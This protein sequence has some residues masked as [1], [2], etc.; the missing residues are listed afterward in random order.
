MGQDVSLHITL[1][2]P[3]GIGPEVV[4]SSLAD[5][6]GPKP[7]IHGHREVLARAARLLDLPDPADTGSLVR[8]PDGVPDPFADPGRTQW[9][10]LTEATQAAAE[11]HVDALVTAPINKETI[12]KAGFSFPGHTDYLAQRAGTEAA[13]MFVGPSLRVVLATVHLPLRDVAEVLTAEKLT[14]VLRLALRSLAFDFGLRG[15]RVAVAGLNPHAGEGGL[16]GDEE[17]RVLLPAMDAC[18]QI[19]ASSLLPEAPLGEG[20]TL[21]GPFPADTVFRQ[22]QLGRYDA[23]VAMYHDQALI[24]V[25]LLEFE[26]TVNVT[27]GLPYVRTSPA[28]GT[29]A[30]IAW[31]GKASSV[32]MRAALDLAVSVAGRRLGKV[33]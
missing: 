9:A 6:S 27:I 2:D 1:G 24:P 20:P 16:L 8:E 31:T 30:D 26:H 11:G 23:V 13:M 3:T 19:L 28:H 25:K 5:W 33:G 17:Q 21:H 29:A 32:S 7:I 12:Q 4:V 18:R 14:A 22:A 15:P 10:Q